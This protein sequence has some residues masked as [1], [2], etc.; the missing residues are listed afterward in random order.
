MGQLFGALGIADSE[1]AF[2]GVSGQALIWDATQRVFQQYNEDMEAAL[3]LFVQETTDRHK[4]RYELPGGGESQDEDESSSTETASVKRS[5]SW[6]VAYP[7]AQIGD[8]LSYTD[9]ELGYLTMGAY[10]A[11]VQTILNRSNN[12]TFRKVLRAIFKNTNTTFTDKIWGALTCVPLANGDSVVYPPPYGTTAEATQQ[13]YIG[14]SYA[15][16]AVSNANNPFKLL[17]DKLEPMYGFPQGGSPIVALCNGSTVPYAR[18][19]SGFDEY[20]NRYNDP[21]DNIT[22]LTGLPGL[23]SGMR[24]VGVDSEAGVVIVEWPR[25]PAGYIIGLHMD[26]AKPVKRRVDPGDT[27]LTPGLQMWTKTV[28]EPYETAR[29]RNRQ[30]F[31]VGN[32]IGAV[33]VFLAGNSTYAIP[34]GYS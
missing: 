6:D 17:R 28:G 25:I 9:V 5:G 7:I 16:A 14:T 12:A 11:H 27:N 15:E 34:A 2:A 19:L 1:R 31:G 22:T 33:V 13:F 18:A 20:T 4:E 3:S 24:I 8:S 26:A 30:G 21:G 23:P 29:W 32:R 10:E